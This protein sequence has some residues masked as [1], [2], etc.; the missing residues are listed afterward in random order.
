MDSPDERALI[1]RI[2]GG[3]RAAFETLVRPYQGRLY[4]TILRITRNRADAAD[5]YQDAMLRAYE[6]LDDFRGDA[7]F[8]S[9]LFRIAV[10]GALMHWRA[11]R[12]R[13]FLAEDDVPRFNWMGGFARPV[14]NWASSAEETA[15]R[16]Q[17]RTVLTE[18][19]DRLPD[20]DRTIVWLKDVEGLSHA[21]IAAATGS[22]ALAVRSRLHRARLRLRE[23]IGDRFGVPA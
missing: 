1:A 23:W 11:R 10:N 21:E 19:M 3:D 13:P 5:L 7:S 17:L 4:Q 20:L 6:R 16:A 14:V 15:H 12:R 2:R 18:A 9:W 22:T 8:K